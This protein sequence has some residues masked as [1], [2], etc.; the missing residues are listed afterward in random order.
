MSESVYD[1]PHLYDILFSDICNS[2]IQFL[3]AVFKRYAAKKVRTLIE[4]ACGSGRLLWRLARRGFTVSGLDLNPKAVA[5]CNRKLRK[6]Q[7][8]ESA[9]VG[10]MTAFS[11][12]DF[13]RKKPFDAAF[14]LVSSFLHLTT[15]NKARRHLRCV[16]DVL[17]PNGLYILGL[18]LKPAGQADCDKESWSVRHGTMSIQSHLAS[19]SWNKQKRL[20]T[21]E[22]QINAKSPKKSYNIVDTF[23]MRTYSAAQF[24]AL[25]KK[26]GCFQILATYSFDYNIEQPIQVNNKTE[27]VL[28]I[29]KKN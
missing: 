7:L 29:L 6:H 8:P 18:H 17:A 1:Y 23:S 22:F 11:L 21:I 9:V 5:Y 24:Y 4:P 28:F 2:E 10:D 12:A 3:A 19:L 26:A 15:E 27:D 13:K 14:N 25:L 20:E 16:A